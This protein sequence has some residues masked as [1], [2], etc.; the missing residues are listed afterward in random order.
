MFTTEL[1]VLFSQLQ[2]ALGRVFDRTIAAQS[3]RL[4][5]SQVPDSGTKLSINGR[6]VL[7]TESGAAND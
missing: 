2:L 6:P 5:D 7:A 4:I 3:S 1:A